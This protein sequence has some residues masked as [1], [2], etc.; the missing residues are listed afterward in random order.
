MN[1]MITRTILTIFKLI[2]TRV[3]LA[4]SMDDYQDDE[5]I[6]DL[7][8]P[9]VICIAHLLWV[10]SCLYICDIQDLVYSQRDWGL[11]AVYGNT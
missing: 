9:D 4:I 3:T 7:D 2:E 1:I 11:V 6:V 10:P 8:S 5:T